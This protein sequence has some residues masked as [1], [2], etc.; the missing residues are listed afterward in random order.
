MT[1]IEVPAV[2]KTFL[3]RTYMEPKWDKDD[4]IAPFSSDGKLMLMDA[5]DEWRDMDAIRW[6]RVPNFKSAMIFRSEYG[7]FLLQDSRGYSFTIYPTEFTE[8]L[9]KHGMA[10][11]GEIEEATWQ[12]QKRSGKYT[13]KEVD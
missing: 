3:Y 12:V 13:I 4:P 7:K 10:K 11:G 5:R 6:M 2:Q 1:Q 8:V 9:L